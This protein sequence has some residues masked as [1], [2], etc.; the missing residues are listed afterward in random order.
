[1]YDVKIK[2]STLTDIAIEGFN[3]VEMKSVKSIMW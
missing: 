3:S 2:V 1:M